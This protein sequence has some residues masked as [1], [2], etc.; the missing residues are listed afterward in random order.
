MRRQ[1]P[2]PAVIVDALVG[3]QEGRFAMDE[4]AFQ[5]FY[6]RTAGPLAGYLRRLT[7]NQAVAEDLV[8]DAYLRFLGAIHPPA[9]DEHRKN[10]LFRIATNL[11]RDHFRRAGRQQPLGEV[12]VDAARPQVGRGD[13][14]TLLERLSPRDRELLLLAYVEGLTHR[15]IAQ[16]TGLM[17]ASVKALLHRARRRFAGVLR[18]A[19]LAGADQAGGT[20]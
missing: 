19:G 14:W 1:L 10:Y 12:P 18:D 20:P 17:R 13:V 7:G 16:V 6:A 9:G 11:A 5:A 15:E 4:P 3:V 8:Q 2:S